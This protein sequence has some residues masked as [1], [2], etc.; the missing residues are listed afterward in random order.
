L[1]S[2][3]AAAVAHLAERAAQPQPL[4]AA[5]AVLVDHIPR[6]VFRRRYWERLNP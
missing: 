2:S 5:V 1:L 4:L 6:A 3:A